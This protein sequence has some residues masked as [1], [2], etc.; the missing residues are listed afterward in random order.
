VKGAE[1]NVVDPSA[2]RQLI[3][4]VSAG[5][6][7]NL[8]FKRKAAFPDKI[9]R[10]MIA[11]AN[12]AGGTLLIGVDDDGNL[13]G[14]RYPDEESHVIREALQ[15]HCRPTLEYEEKVIALSI[16]KSILRY[17]IPASPRRPHYFR[18]SSRLRE[19]YIRVRDMSMKASREMTE[20]VRRGRQKKDIQ[21]TYGAHES[22][23]MR[24]LDDHPS[25][26][27]KEFQQ[28][29]GLDR[30][31]AARKLVTLVLASVIR[32]TPTEKGDI[33]SRK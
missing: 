20:V 9:I 29:T 22:Q 13:Q 32:I 6:N 14:V 18:I 33:Y 26:T 7:I 4:L 31:I 15:K 28:L 24:Y 19:T 17:D 25:I 30:F 1:H 5:E 23:L 3:L 21:F 11:F 16:K 10:E 2:I 8:E 27:L 12:T